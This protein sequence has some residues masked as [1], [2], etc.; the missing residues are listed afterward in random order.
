MTHQAWTHHEAVINHVRL[1]YVQAGP[2]DGP[3]VVLLHGFPEF[4][5]S[6]RHQLPALAAAGFRVVAPDLRG[7]NRS[8]KPPGVA[9]YRLRQLVADVRALIVHLG[10]PTA[11]LVGHDWGGVI[12][13]A[14]AMRHPEVVSRLAILNAPHPGAYR[15][16]LR[17]NPAQ[18]RRSWYVLAV[19]LPVVPD[20]LGRLLRVRIGALLRRSSVRPDAF[21]DEDVRAYIHALGQPGALTASLNYYRALLRF[22]GDMP[23]MPIPARTLVI[24]GAQ[25][26]A[27]VPQLSEGLDRWVPHVQVERLPQASH[28]VQ[29]DAPEVVSRL[30]I[31]FLT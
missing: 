10:S 28:W 27:L 26:V 1:H 25:D 19:Q 17:R 13:W 8:E 9:A 18:W 6:W 15:R 31:D 2:E 24:W 4:W 22:P 16:E 21:T 3:L 30:L 20:A 7:Y 29:H 14:A 12:A 11:A 23:L 5:Y